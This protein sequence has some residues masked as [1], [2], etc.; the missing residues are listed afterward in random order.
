MKILHIP[1]D[2]LLS[3]RFLTMSIV[4]NGRTI[5]CNMAIAAENLSLAAEIN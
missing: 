1:V 4:L 3:S 2:P 5:R